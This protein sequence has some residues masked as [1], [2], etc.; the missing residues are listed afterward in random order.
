[1]CCLGLRCVQC[2]GL[3]SACAAGDGGERGG[4]VLTICSR[5]GQGESRPGGW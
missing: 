2:V 4:A 5:R 1:M 3:V